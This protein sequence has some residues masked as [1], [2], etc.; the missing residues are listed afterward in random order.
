MNLLDRYLARTILVHTVMVM[1]VLLALMTLLNFIGQQDDIGEGTYDVKGAFIVTFL[2]LPQQAYELLPI[3]ALIGAII[4]LGG[5]ARDSE[6][7]ILRAAGVSISRIALS[8]GFAGIIVAA[9]LWVIGEYFAPPADQYAQQYKVFS[10][11]SQLEIAGSRSAWLRQGDWFINVRRQAAENLF[12]GVYVYGW[13]PSGVL[14]GSAGP[15][16]P[17]RIPPAD[18]VLTELHGDAARAGRRADARR[19][20]REL[21]GAEFNADFLGLAVNEPGSLP[22]RDLYSYAQH[23]KANDLDASVWD[24]AFW[25][26][27]A[28]LAGAIVVCVFAV[29]F[30]FGPLRSAGAGARTVLGIMA[31]V[32]FILLTQ[33]LENSGQV[34]DLNPL[35]VAW[36]PDPA[37]GDH[38]RRHDLADALARDPH[39]PHRA[40]EILQAPAR[41]IEEDPGQI[42][43][44]G[45]EHQR[46]W[47]FGKRP[48]RI[49]QRPKADERQQYESRS[50]R[51]SH[52]GI[53]PVQRLPSADCRRMRQARIRAS[54]HRA[55]SRCR[56]SRM[57]P[58]AAS[59]GTGRRRVPCVEVVI[60]SPP[61]SGITTKVAMKSKRHDQQAVVKQ[62]REAAEESGGSGDRGLFI[63]AVADSNASVLFLRGDALLD[64]AFAA[65]QD[66]AHLLDIRPTG[67]AGDGLRQF[68]PAR[69]QVRSRAASLT[70]AVIVVSFSGFAGLCRRP[71]SSPPCCGPCL[72]YRGRPGLIAVDVDVAPVDFAFFAP[73]RA[74][75]RVRAPRSARSARHAASPRGSSG[76]T[77]VRAPRKATGRPRPGA[78]SRCS[79][80][81]RVAAGRGR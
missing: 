60:A 64:G 68:M 24:I 18:W 13:T 67:D 28:R 3:G 56:N 61:V 41:R 55:P 11:F 5:L 76:K 10:R 58:Q 12:G 59:R 77:S 9:F 70:T 22:I 43:E 37:D 57:R 26:R 42:C 19:G 27:I 38:R 16:R 79:A 31:G 30:A 32:L 7:T 66:L 71:P 40:G 25:S 6:L 44:C 47:Q 78:S 35:L 34:Y 51:E 17:P 20:P 21:T 73:A 1:G 48:A 33:T 49:A 62:C 52:G 2:H 45:Q 15:R 69:P 81:R 54:V 39:H 23:L 4:G 65:L 63:H 46:R 36:A 50:D 74:G 75:V 53:R 72:G 80:G 14:R 29:P 8:A